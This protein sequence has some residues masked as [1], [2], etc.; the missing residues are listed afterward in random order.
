[1]LEVIGPEHQDHKIDRHVRL[2]ADRQRPE[3][4]LV[5]AFHRIVGYGRA[6]RLPLLDDLKA[7]AE[8][9][10]QDSRPAPLGREAMPAG[11][12]QGGN[13]AVGVG[14]SVTKNGPD[15]GHGIGPRIS[16]WL[17]ST[18]KDGLLIFS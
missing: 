13:G 8:L 1:M 12:G 9:P 3:A 14:V 11:A 17:S 4:V 2:E 7:I 10:P 5:A 6:A 16:P 18:G 15:S